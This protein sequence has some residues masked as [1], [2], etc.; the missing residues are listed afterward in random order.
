MRRELRA[1]IV[2]YHLWP[3]EGWRSVHASVY[4]ALSESG[5]LAAA[6]AFYVGLAPKPEVLPE[7]LAAI[8]V[9]GKAQVIQLCHGLNEI[10]TLHM[11]SGL[12]KHSDPDTP[13][14]YLHC[15]SARRKP[16]DYG[17]QEALDHNAMMLHFLV[18]RWREALDHMA[19]GSDVVG[20]NVQLTPRLHVSGNFWWCRAGALAAL[21]PPAV[22]PRTITQEALLVH[23]NEAEF[24]IGQIQRGR[25][26]QM[27]R[28]G[29]HHY[30]Q[31]YP[32]E[33]YAKPCR[34]GRALAAQHA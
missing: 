27:H 8:D 34:D 2:V 19:A 18:E 21:E 14:L 15:R 13:L 23:R 9:T 3:C 26:F 17:Y 22:L 29:V 31:R 25:M 24:W 1:P 6:Q 30:Q 12:A 20:C 28:S 7:D 4:A 11:A 32:R 10:P 33:R 16:G 5:L